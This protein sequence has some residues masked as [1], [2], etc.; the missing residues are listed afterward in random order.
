MELGQGAAVGRLLGH[1]PQRLGDGRLDMRPDLEPAQA[2]GLDHPVLRPGELVGPVDGPERL[3]AMAAAAELD[4]V[5]AHG[6]AGDHER[7]PA[8]EEDDPGPRIAQELHGHEG[9][10]G[11]LAGPGLADEGGVRR[12]RARRVQ[13]PVERHA[14]PRGAEQEGRTAEAPV[15]AGALADTG[16]RGQAGDGGELDPRSGGCSWPP[17]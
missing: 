12:V 15:L 1:V 3:H 11:R 13:G 7:A 6:K 17:G 16:D 14:A 9:K 10:E 8:V 5:P 2:Q 4:P